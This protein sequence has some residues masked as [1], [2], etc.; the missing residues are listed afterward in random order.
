M[1]FFYLIITIINDIIIN[2]YKYYDPHPVVRIPNTLG[3]TLAMFGITGL[4][5]RFML[6][7]YLFFKTK[8]YLNAYRLAIFVFVFIYQF[9]GSFMFN[10]V[11]LTLWAI[12]FTPAFHQ[13]DSENVYQKKEV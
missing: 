6:E 11:E 2:Y 12:A 7:M 10:I 5:F 4:I 8:V 9:T 13:F 3:E 1:K